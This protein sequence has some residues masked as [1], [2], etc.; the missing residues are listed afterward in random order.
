[1]MLSIL[2]YEVDRL[3]LT[4]FL[5]PSTFSRSRKRPFRYPGLT[6]SQRDL[7]SDEVLKHAQGELV[8]TLPIPRRPS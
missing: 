6:V 1:M 8:Y 7:S 2:R 4:G 3:N 5:Q